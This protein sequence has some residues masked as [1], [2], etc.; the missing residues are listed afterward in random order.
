MIPMLRLANPSL[1]E[2][3]LLIALRG[4]S[5]VS[6][7]IALFPR[8]RTIPRIKVRVLPSL[9]SPNPNPNPTRLFHL[10]LNHSKVLTKD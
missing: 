8:E 9:Y 1:K 4:T 2:A 5:L 6:F 10:V 7:H 3:R